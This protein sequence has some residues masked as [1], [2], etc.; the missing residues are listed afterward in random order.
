L[1]IKDYWVIVT[2]R[3]WIFVLMVAITSV[4]AYVYSKSQIPIF[5][6]T[7][8]LMITP[9]R[10]DYGQTLVGQNLLRQL[11][12]VI[13]STQ[14]TSKVGESFDLGGGQLR[15][16][17]KVSAVPEDMVIQVDAY[18]PDPGIAQNI[19]RAVADAFI[20][21]QQVRMA[22]LQSTERIN[23]EL[24]DQP[25]PG[26]LDYPKTKV[27]V[28]AAAILGLLIGGIVAFV[29]EY[30]D[31]TIKSA[32]DV[33]RYVALPSIGSIPTITTAEARRAR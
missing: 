31:D 12:R 29:L 26:V 33:Q 21:N 15:S 16:K 18:D 24:L 14:L 22:P 13:E 20:A 4:S 32:E 17:I 23:A 25:L 5:R 11:V 6:S 9:G 2:K 8:T 28:I 27:T 3:W 7:A 1:Q 19:A 30:L 10:I